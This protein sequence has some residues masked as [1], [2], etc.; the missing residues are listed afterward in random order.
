MRAMPRRDAPSSPWPEDMIHSPA[1]LLPHKAARAAPTA[2]GTKGKVPGGCDY[3]WLVALLCDW[4]VPLPDSPLSSVVD[5]LQNSARHL[6][7]TETPLQLAPGSSVSSAAPCKHGETTLHLARDC[8][9]GSPF[10]C[11]FLDFELFLL[12]ACKL[13][14]DLLR[15]LPLSRDAEKWQRSAGRRARWA[16]RRMHSQ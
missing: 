2:G 9:R 12:P 3:S 14:S 13:V 7:I 11:D 8:Q 1:L 15:L 10:F 4:Q 16:S 6:R 5:T